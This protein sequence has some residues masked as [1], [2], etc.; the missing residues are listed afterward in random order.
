MHAKKKV[1][2]AAGML[3]GMAALTGCTANAKPAATM[4]PKAMQ[5]QTAQP[6]T[7]QPD[8]AQASP[9]ATISVSEAPDADE[10]PAPIHLEVDGEEAETGAIME[11]GELLLP[12]EETGE[13]LGWKAKSEQSEEETQTKRIV[14]LEKDDSRITVVW[15]VSDNTAK[16]ISWQKDGL[17]IPVDARITTVDDTVYVPAAFFETAMDVRIEHGETNVIVSAP[18]PVDTPKM[19]EDSSGEND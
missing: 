18:K 1:L 16:N 9:E 4:T 17:L 6:A 12:L 3:A 10:S 19:A 2:L 14:T 8:A 13:K 11:R 5:Q 7:A 15:T